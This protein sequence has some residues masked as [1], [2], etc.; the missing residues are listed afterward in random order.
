MLTLR[1]PF[2]PA[3][4]PAKD[5]FRSLSVG[6]TL[7]LKAC[8]F[9]EDHHARV[10]EASESLL[11]FRIGESWKD[12]LMKA[13]TFRQCKK[14]MLISLAIGPEE[15]IVQGSRS[16]H[17]FCVIDVAIHPG[18]LQWSSDEFHEESRRVLLNLRSYFM[19]F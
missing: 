1:L 11:R 16:I 10:L 6:S 17:R 18:S 7:I 8:G 2:L 4:E 9:I 19:A 13:I 3:T 14:P 12:R 15:S 5:R